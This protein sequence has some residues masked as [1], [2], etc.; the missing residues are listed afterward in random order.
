V[1]VNEGGIRAQLSIDI[2]AFQAQVNQ[3]L[4]LS[5]KLGAGLKGIPTATPRLPADKLEHDVQQSSAALRVLLSQLNVIPGV[6]ALAQ[7]SLLG[8]G[9]SGINMGT[10]LA[11]GAAAGV[12]ALTTAMIA[13]AKAAIELEKNIAAVKSIK[14]ELDTKAATES[15][16]SLSATVGQSS[17]SLAKSLYDIFSSINVPQADAIKL[18]EQFSRGAIAAQ[19]DAK[20]FGT[21]II[22]S[23]NAYSK[24]T[25]D[26]SHFA[27]VFFNTV[28]D[29]VVTGQQLAAGLGPL[30]ASAKNAGVSFEELGALIV[31]VTKQGGDAAQNLNN[32]NNLLAK[33]VTKETAQDFAALGISLED[34]TGK[35]RSPIAILT[36]LKVK[37]DGMTEAA[38]ASALQS[39]FPDLQA[40]QGAQVILNQLDVVNAALQ[41]NQ[42]EVGSA[43]TAYKTMSQTSA[44]AL[45]RLKES[46]AALA[47]EIGDTLTPA[48]AASASGWAIGLE[49][50]RKYLADVKRLA[51]EAGIGFTPP[52]PNTPG[53]K[54]TAAQA[55]GGEVGRQAAAAPRLAEVG[56]ATVAER[57]FE[58]LNTQATAA[59]ALFGDLGADAANQFFAAFDTALGQQSPQLAQDFGALVGTTASQLAG[60]WATA[61]G[62]T[63]AAEAAFVDQMTE[64]ARRLL[65]GMG[66]AF[67]SALRE[68]VIA[69]A[70]A[71]FDGAGDVVESFA[72]KLSK[73]LAN[74]AEIAAQVLQKK[75]NLDTILANPHASEAAIASLFAYE[76]ELGDV[77]AAI[78][79]LSDRGFA[80]HLQALLNQVALTTD[81]TERQRVYAEVLETA[82]AAT[83]A[84]TKGKAAA[85]AAAAALAK[86]LDDLASSI[87]PALT[88]QQAAQVAETK[89]TQGATA[90]LAQA[91]QLAGVDIGQLGDLTQL[92]GNQLAE[93]KKQVDAAAKGFESFAND[94]FR[95]RLGAALGALEG[96]VNT[97]TAALAKQ[98]VA[99]GQTGQA[100]Y[101]LLHAIGLTD[102]EID[103]LADD[104]LAGGAAATRAQAEI[105]AAAKGFDGFFTDEL[106]SRYSSVLGT[107]A[108][109]VDAT[110]AALA[111]QE[112]AAGHADA[113]LALLLRH[114]S[115]SITPAGIEALTKALEA[116][117]A[118]AFAAQEK[119]SALTTYARDPRNGTITLKI[120]VD[121][122]NV[123]EQIGQLQQSFQRASAQRAEAAADLGRQEAK[124]AQNFAQ[125]EDA[126]KQNLTQEVRQIRQARNDAFDQ[127]LRDNTVTQSALQKSLDQIDAAARGAL[128]TY[129]QT[130]QDAQV[131]LALAFANAQKSYDDGV[132][133]LAAQS[134]QAIDAAA[135]AVSSGLQALSSAMTTFNQQQVTN[136]FTASVARQAA[137]NAANGFTDT[138]SLQSAQRAA[139]VQAEGAAGLQQQEQANA[140]AKAQHSVAQQQLDATKALTEALANAAKQMEDLRKAQQH[141]E[142]AAQISA[143]NAINAANRQRDIAAKGADFYNANTAQTK[144]VMLIDGVPYVI[145]EDVPTA[146]TGDGKVPLGGAF[147]AESEARTTAAEQFAATQTRFNQR[148][149]Q[150]DSQEA[151]AALRAK[152]LLEALDEQKQIQAEAFRRQRD[153]QLR[154]EADATREY[155][156]ALQRLR[157]QEGILLGIRGLPT[158]TETAEAIAARMDLGP[159]NF[160]ENAQIVNLETQVDF[161]AEAIGAFARQ[162]R[163]T[164]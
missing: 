67:Y 55:L 75:L 61:T 112:E 148:T 101:D 132:K 20:T 99:A 25:S 42:A 160:L 26:A 120:N 91:A 71:A 54:Q 15:I 142:T 16:R 103:K 28:R 108:S 43:E 74:S 94:E 45:D 8:V 19:T 139:Q 57:E 87:L 154:A 107:L 95:G 155:Q 114:A 135:K 30:S 143:G 5:D 6:G 12:V 93:V 88:S 105:T 38:R 37:L 145:E 136:A 51:A 90:A 128:T 102:A 4:A 115:T 69:K 21:A 7:S 2:A 17:E 59:V 113:A 111:K 62:P 104:L 82:R 63:V 97:E 156:Q 1:A 106:K 13:S 124:S 64:T 122:A 32:L 41:A 138:Q 24:A 131:G 152:K 144:R 48:I 98:Q 44:A 68:H 14:L 163:G 84:D 137:E 161:L 81:A 70:K 58:K 27:D 149:A 10:A 153:A 126:I 150:L 29:G 117:G 96:A 11:G 121:I 33:L 39:I 3:A 46:V 34:A 65:P 60:L 36:D 22:G 116:G 72:E 56:G 147:A 134:A 123:Q 40:R 141:A 151:A 159:Q 18:L 118:A 127:F 53:V 89:A 35:L 73:G 100:Y 109:G 130:V 83:D 162:S 31:G 77:E 140:L 129:R 23:L 9:Q 164:A 78:K 157:V 92:T 52:E 86:P 125:Q 158:A 133:G 146:Q 80:A 66:E 110:T 119:I 79:H 76:K 50:F 47:G 85:A 49:A